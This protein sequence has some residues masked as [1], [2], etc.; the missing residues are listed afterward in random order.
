MASFIDNPV[1]NSRI[2]DMAA[3]RAFMTSVL[4]SWLLLLAFVPMSAADQ[5][6]APEAQLARK[7]AAVSGPGAVAF[8]LENRSSLGLA[9]VK[10]IQGGLLSE[11]AALGVHNVSAEQAA[12]SLNVALS[13]N[14]E[15]YVWV[16]EIRQG[17]GEKT[18]VMVTIKRSAA[19]SVER[20]TVP[21]AI[22]GSL[23]WSD[24]HRIL[25]LVLLE[26]N[27]QHMIALEPERV[28]V[29]AMQGNRWL[30]A[31]SLS[32]AHLRPW[33]RDL[34]GRLVLRKDHLFDTYLPGI[35][36][37]STVASPMGLDCR[38]SDDPWPLSIQ[39]PLNGF[40]A[41]ARNFFTGALSPGIGNQ[42]S[43]PSFYAAAALPREK[44]VL[45]LFSGRDG[46]VHMLDGLT[47]Q[48]LARSNWGSDI[49][50]VRSGCGTGWQVLATGNRSDDR[51]TVQ[52]FE[53]PD[54]EAEVAGKPIEFGGTITALWPDAD[55]TGAMAVSKNAETGK[56]EAYRLSI[57]CGQ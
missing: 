20:P 1:Y 27:P 30:E 45:W 8:N 48:T 37:Q 36:C 55:G 39:P 22:R 43:V 15:S 47:E 41:P 23:L 12:A 26:G 40:F 21:L 29:L 25:D 33:P 14:L 18:V 7:I 6:G 11:L 32:V 2:P 57:A 53:V 54:R 28:I 31:Q 17:D 42:T 56:Y 35:F 3:L 10:V 9:D 16:A 5:W 4:R 44:Y 38:E 51:D 24:D 52:A 19:A 49:V 46:K 34:H 13:E 50:T